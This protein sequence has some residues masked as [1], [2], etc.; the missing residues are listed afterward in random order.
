MRTLHPHTTPT[1]AVSVCGLRIHSPCI[2]LLYFQGRRRVHAHT[3]PDGFFLYPLQTLGPLLNTVVSYPCYLTPGLRSMYGIYIIIFVC[4][5]LQSPFIIKSR[6]S[7]YVRRSCMQRYHTCQMHTVHDIG[8]VCVVS[9][10]RTYR[11]A[12]SSDLICIRTEP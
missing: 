4:V 6:A 7:M 8:A 12:Y 9:C 3:V 10:M 2:V 1:E 11:L 5:V